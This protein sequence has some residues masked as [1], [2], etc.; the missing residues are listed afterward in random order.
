MIEICTMTSSFGTKRLGGA[1]SIPESIEHC[2]KT[3][4]P[5]LVKKCTMPLTALHCVSVVVT[6]KC[7][8]E[9]KDGKPVVTAM[10]PGLTK[11]ELIACTEAELTFADTIAEMEVE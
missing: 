2:S 6:E 9:F 8:V 11:E 10:A 4:E 5:K 3:G 7:I 1:Y